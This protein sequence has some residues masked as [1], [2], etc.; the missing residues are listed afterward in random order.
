[1][2]VRRKLYKYTSYAV[3]FYCKKTCNLEKA[4]LI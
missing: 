2:K 4:Y 3:E 1:M